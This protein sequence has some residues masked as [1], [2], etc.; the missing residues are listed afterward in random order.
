M[1]DHRCKGKDHQRKGR[2]KGQE[3]DYIVDYLFFASH[4]QPCPLL[5][6]S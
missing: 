4:S 3:K 6:S 1:V 2:Y 5:G